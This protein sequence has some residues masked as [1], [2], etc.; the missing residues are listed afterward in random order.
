MITSSL[1]TLTG[2]EP[3]SCLL[4]FLIRSEAVI[5]I[6]IIICYPN[7]EVA[8]AKKGQKN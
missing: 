7:A 5:I 8:N 1:F 2:F 6:I 4:P 3:K